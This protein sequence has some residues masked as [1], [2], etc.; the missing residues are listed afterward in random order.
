MT[1][2]HR[3]NASDRRHRSRRYRAG[4]TFEAIGPGQWT[5]RPPG[6]WA[7]PPGAEPD[8]R[9]WELERRRGEPGHPG[10]WY[11]FGPGAPTGTRAGDSLDD[12]MA[13]TERLAAET[14]R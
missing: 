3:R 1:G 11:V 7:T 14:G 4:I 13:L 9:V 8:S 6:M 5:T 2:H 10:G 12:A